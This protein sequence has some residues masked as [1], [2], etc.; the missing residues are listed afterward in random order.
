MINLKLDDIT[1]FFTDFLMFEN[2]QE[3]V[4]ALKI[5]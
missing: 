4:L 3:I 5:K 2:L 1:S